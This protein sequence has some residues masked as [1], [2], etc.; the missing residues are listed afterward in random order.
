VK[1]VTLRAVCD[2]M[3]REQAPAIAALPVE[4]GAR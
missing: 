2:T 3:R 4:G 1:D